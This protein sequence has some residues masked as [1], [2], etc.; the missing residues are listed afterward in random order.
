[1]IHKPQRKFLTL[2]TSLHFFKSVGQLMSKKRSDFSPQ[3]LMLA[4]R[5]IELLTHWLFVSNFYEWLLR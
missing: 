3:M 4:I 5:E 2:Q 1:M